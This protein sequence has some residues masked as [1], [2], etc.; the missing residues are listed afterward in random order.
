MDNTEVYEKQLFAFIE[1]LCGLSINEAHKNY[2][3]SYLGKRMAEL[4][5]DLPSFCRFVQNDDSECVK[6]INEAAI[7]ETY[8]FREEQQFDFLKNVFFPKFEGNKITIWSAACSTGEEPIS[9]YALAKA[10][11]KEPLVYAT[12]IDTEAL[13]ILAKGKY[14]THSFRNDGKKYHPLLEKVGMRTGTTYELFPESKV[15]FR[16]GKFNLTSSDVPP[17]AKESVNLLFLRNVFIYFSPEL[18]RT[19]IRKVSEY[20]MPGGLLF[21]SVN[22]IAG[23]NCD[24]DVP[25]VKE[26]EGSVYFFRKVDMATKAQMKKQVLQGGVFIKP[27]TRT[28][29][30]SNLRRASAVLPQHPMPVARPELTSP[31]RRQEQESKQN[32]VVTRHEEIENLAEEIFLDL[33]N[34]KINEAKSKIMEYKFRPENLEYKAYFNGLIAETENDERSAAQH[35]LR[36]NLYEPKFWPS[37]FKLGLIYEKR[38][39]KKE[40]KKTFATCASLL[41]NYV[42]DNKI[43]YNFLVEQFNP[44]YFLDMCRKYING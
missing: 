33:G 15:N 41:E 38:G 19:V 6:L 36:A 8:F 26:H 42:K 16:R 34:K 30:L 35:F 23:T 27:P 13:S 18:R 37:Y 43:C 39:N 40:S 31:V 1:Q 5:M 9:L 22:D 14:T 24:D 21:L 10:C 28:G 7:N 2:M 29:S 3:R 17:I 20:L 44:S 12:D 11:G 32:I 4:D 25:L